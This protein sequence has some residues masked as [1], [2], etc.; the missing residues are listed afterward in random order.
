[1]TI[2]HQLPTLL[3]LSLCLGLSSVSG[4]DAESSDG[5]EERDLEEMEEDSDGDELDEEPFDDA[6]PDELRDDDDA[7]P[8][9]EP[10]YGRGVGWVPSY[11]CEDGQQY[12]AGLCYDE[13]KE[14]YTNVLE[15]CYEDC[16]EGYSDMGLYCIH[17]GV[18]GWPSYWKDIYNRG[19]GTLPIPDCGAGNEYDAG[20][21]YPECADGYYGVGPVCYLE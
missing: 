19:I 14:G 17:Y 11:G 15:L 20:L 3:S 12:D 7:S 2:H 21:C 8:S 6:G 1:M 18:A 10:S 5:F 16:E 13:C 9:E 4:C